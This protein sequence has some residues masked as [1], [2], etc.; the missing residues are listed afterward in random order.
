V[1]RETLT[2]SINRCG[3]VGRSTA[4]ASRNYRRRTRSGDVAGGGST[5]GRT[6]ERR[7]D[8]DRSSLSAR[9]WQHLGP[10]S[11][12]RQLSSFT[13]PPLQPPPPPPLLLLLLLLTRRLFH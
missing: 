13:H 5:D 8:V 11:S 2:R 1:E 6:D 4:A 9:R 3:A 7:L 12:R 10:A